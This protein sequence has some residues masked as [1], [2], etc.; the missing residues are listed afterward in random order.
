[1]TSAE[2]ARCIRDLGLAADT[3]ALAGLRNRHPGAGHRELLLRLAIL[4]FG[5]ELVARAYDWQP[6]DGP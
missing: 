6:T 5:R 3:I 1:M 4:R 2:K